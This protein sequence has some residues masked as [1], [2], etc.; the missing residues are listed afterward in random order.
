MLNAFKIKPF[1]LEP[2]FADWQD[3]P[4]FVGNPKKDLPVDDWLAQIKA[5][6]VERKVP[7]E[8]W[9]KVAQHYMADNAKTRFEELKAVMKNMHGGKYCWTW[10]NYK[11]AMRNMGCA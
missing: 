7:R 10:K 8:Y 2:I 4:L 6:C 11:I 5:G 1:N 3:A 9:H